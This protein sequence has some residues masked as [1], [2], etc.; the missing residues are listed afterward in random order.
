M[1][2]VGNNFDAKKSARCHQVSVITKLVQ[3]GSNFLLTKVV[4]F[5][6]IGNLLTCCGWEPDHMLGDICPQPKA[7]EYDARRG[8]TH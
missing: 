2:F 6:R 8:D 4:F 5:C 1:V 3:T 7:E